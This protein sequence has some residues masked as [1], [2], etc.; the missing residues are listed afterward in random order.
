M[1]DPDK[2][3]E[4]ILNI[5]DNAIKYT[6]EG[7]VEVKAKAKPN[8]VLVSIADTGAG[9]SEE[10]IAKMF[11]SFSRGAAGNQFF[12]EGMGLGLYIARQFTEIQKGKIWAESKGKGAGSTFFIEL[13]I[14]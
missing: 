5:I 12:T 10:E 3:R 1:I 9:M 8:S 2:T 7:S 4:I 11:K 13:P 14:D 6:Q